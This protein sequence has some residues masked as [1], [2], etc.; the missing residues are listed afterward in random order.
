M[1]TGLP[2]DPKPDKPVEKPVQFKQ[3]LKGWGLAT[4]GLV[5]IV[6]GLMTVYDIATRSNT[7]TP[8]QEKKSQKAPV[9][10]A[11][12]SN[13]TDL[14]NNRIADKQ[15]KATTP[16]S[17][18]PD[19]N[20]YLPQH[21]V[22]ALASVANPIE[23][24]E[25]DWKVAELRRSLTATRSQWRRSEPSS[26]PTARTTQAKAQPLPTM[27]EKRLNVARRIQEIQRLQAKLQRGD[28]SSVDIPQT[29]SPVLQNLNRQF[30]PP[31]TN[32][33]GYTDSNQYNA[34]V[35]GKLKLPVG[36]LI[37][38]ITSMK[39]IS[40]YAGTLKAI[41]SQD[42][43]DLNY[44][45]VLVPKG[46]EVMIKSVNASNINEPIQARVGL[47]VQWIIRPDGKRIDL[48]KSTGLDREGVAAIKD[49]VDHHFMAQF[50]GVA[51]YA[52][53]ASE[54]SYAGSGSNNDQSY[55]GNVGENVR[56]QASPLAQKYLSL[57]PTKTIRAGQSMNI[58]LEDELFI[59][60]WLDIYKDY[61]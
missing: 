1:E 20:P 53:V 59:E 26:M 41:V 7:V 39:T 31:P 19:D 60:P 25:N 36:T 16:A 50:L 9:V 14:V 58:I 43:Y 6:L 22:S 57:T 47:T 15:T 21:L 2:D 51:A 34:N 23:D 40:D 18:S 8:S 5:F 44:E 24:A 3:K 46:S 12:P 56:Q 35:D 29:E 45:Y 11:T 38:A 48:S 52:L 27:E 13:V 28:T 61:L 33:V 4:G 37:P 10:E 17:N 30:T 42:V 49:K 54:S 32:I 55:L